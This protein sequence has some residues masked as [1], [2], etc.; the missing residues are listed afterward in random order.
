M[1]ILDLILKK[2]NAGTL[3]RDEIA[4]FVRSYVE[5]TVPEYQVSA[6][7]M[8]IFF[9]G[10]TPEETGFLTREMIDSGETI[11]LSAL[12][13]PFVDKHST[14]GVGDKVSLIL[15]PVAAACGVKVPMM[16]GRSLGHTGGTL[17]KLES[18]PGFRTDLT[19]ARFAEII[20]QCGFAMTGQSKRVVPA[21][22]KLYGLRDVTGTVESVPLITSS[23]LSKKFAEGADALVFD[24]KTGPGAF[25]KNLE[26]ARTLATSLVKTG[27]SLGKQI[28]AVL[29]RMDAPLGAKVGNFIEVEESLALVGSPVA[30]DRVPIDKRSDDLLEVTLRLTAWML[31]A[32]GIVSTVE[33]GLERCR[34]V[35]ADGS[36]WRHMKQNIELQGGNVDDMHA[37]LGT[38]RAPIEQVVSASEDGFLAALDAYCVGMAGVYLG[39]G[40]SKT[41]DEVFTDVGFEILVKPGDPIKR[42]EPIL[43]AWGR[44]EDAME[45]AIATIGDGISILSVVPEQDSMILEEFSTI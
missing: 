14:G 22:R 16:S 20:D 45:R 3:T 7:L 29:T 33:A 38:H 44:S 4:F 27:E 40:R 9:Q 23:I 2:R 6:L 37:A 5:G 31:V 42:G 36:A 26:D 17:D 18:I 15:A 28:I 10:M 41:D 34:E 32:A 8:A 21:D 24:V 19:P 39:A 12:S 13:G 43:R 30:V 25:M 11:D 35:I 1:R